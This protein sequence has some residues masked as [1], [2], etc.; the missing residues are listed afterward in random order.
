MTFYARNKEAIGIG[1]R[2]LNEVRRGLLSR[3]CDEW[4]ALVCRF[5]PHDLRAFYGSTLWFFS[6]VPFTFTALGFLLLLC[7]SRRWTE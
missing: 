3:N 1:L 2:I 6:T 7:S 5:E 4:Y